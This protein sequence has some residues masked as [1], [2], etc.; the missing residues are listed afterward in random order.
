MLLDIGLPRMSGHE[1]CRA[2]RQQP[3]G[4]GIFIVAVTGWGQADDRARTYAAGFN[5]HL[6][7]PL[8][9]DAVRTILASA[10]L[11]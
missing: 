4:R 9:Y 5:A 3:W 6:V 10:L 7:K 2:I 11:T 1:V 8:D